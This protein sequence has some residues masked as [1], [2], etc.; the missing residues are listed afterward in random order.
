MNSVRY[1]LV[2]EGSS[3]KVLMPILEWLLDI[4]GVA[5]VQT[6]WAD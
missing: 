4:H 6:A 1:T 3:D 2:S 5:V